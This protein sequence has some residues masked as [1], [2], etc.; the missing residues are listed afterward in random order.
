MQDDSTSSTE[1]S[2]GSKAAGS[3]E[4]DCGAGKALGQKQR[5]LPLPDWGKPGAFPVVPP[6]LGERNKQN[7]DW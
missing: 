4:K 2:D 1:S 6:E 5:S 7:I 3:L